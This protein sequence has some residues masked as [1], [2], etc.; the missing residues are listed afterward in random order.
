M[1]KTLADFHKARVHPKKDAKS[2]SETG[3]E[4]KGAHIDEVCPNPKR[5]CSIDSATLYGSGVSKSSANPRPNCRT[6]PRIFSHFFAPLSSVYEKLL[7]A[8]HL[9]T[10]SNSFT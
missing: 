7:E 4:R 5:V 9:A 8:G 6:R 2:S 3:I 1:F 10:P